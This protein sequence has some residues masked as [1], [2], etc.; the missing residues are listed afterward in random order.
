MSAKRSKS[1]HVWSYM[2]KEESNSVVCLIC[3]TSFKFTGTT[4][5]LLKHLRLKHPTENEELIKNA[6]EQE[7]KKSKSA[8]AGPSTQPNIM[9]TF[10]AAMKYKDGAPRKQM[11][12]RLVLRLV[13]EDLQPFS[14]IEDRGFC[15]LV[16][17]LDPRYSFPSRRTLA[18]TLLP[19]IFSQERT[20]LEA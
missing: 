11:L 12:D 16:K 5:N 18:R 19:E 17:A 9:D 4:S 6:E 2:R 1:S 20:R 13:V 10:Q 8:A 14:V 15:R 7:A 3:K